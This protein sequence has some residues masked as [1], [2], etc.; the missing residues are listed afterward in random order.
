MAKQLLFED[1]ARTKL[2]K[3]VQTISDAVAITM[4]PTG[5]NVIID[6]NFGNPV[7]TKDGVTVSKE[8]EVEDPFENMGAK[9]VNEVATKTSD[10]AGDGTTTATVLARSIYTEGLRG[11]SL[12]ANPMVVRR[13]IDK[14]VEA[15]V[16][17]IEALAKP[18][19]DKAEIAQVGAISANNDNEIGNLIADA[20]EKVG[21]DGVITV[22]EGKGN[23]TTLSFADGMQF[24]KGYISPYFVTDTEGM[25]CILEDCYILIHESKVSA[26]RDLVPLLEKVSQTGKPLLIIAEDVEGEPLTALV[27]NKLRGVLNIAAVK[28]PGFGDRRKAMLA[29]IAVLTG[30]TVISEDLGIKLESVELAQLGQ[31]KQVE[32]TKDSC[33][34]IEGAG[35]TEALQA[36]VAQIRGQLQKTESEYDREKFQERLAKLTGGVAII[37]VGAA[38][39][40]EMKQTKARMEDALHATRAAVEEGILPGGGVALLRSIEAVTK[41]KGKNDDEKIGINIVARALEGPIRQIAENCGV[42][43]AVIADEVKALSG[44]HGYNA[45]SGEY[46]DMFKAGII[47]PAKVVKNALKNAA[48][49]AGLMLT[50]QVLIT[51]SESTEGGKLAN[52]EGSV[53]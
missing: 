4:G 31:A 12:G 27:V 29:D 43:G 16:E 19:T 7:V 17:A 38:T 49:I 6:K 13:G 11:L 22:E 53:R 51:R 25:K 5:R 45:Y 46:V 28:A 44:A 40:A 26:L 48:S 35:D 18:V 20:V 36:R 34:L 14:A 32:I 41:V 47:D 21:R 50:T 3:G 39:E 15:A 10:I 33:T 23:E 42:D 30:G 37:S 9:L 1:R 52:V 8:V 2:Q 24:D